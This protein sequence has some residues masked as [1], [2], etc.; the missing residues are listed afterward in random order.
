MQTFLEFVSNPRAHDST[1]PSDLQAWATHCLS[2]LDESELRLLNSYRNEGYDDINAF[3]RSNNINWH[4][5]QHRTHAKSP[6]TYQRMMR[7]ATSVIDRIFQKCRAPRPLTLF[8]GTNRTWIERGSNFVP[9]ASNVGKEMTFTGYSSASL[10]V[11]VAVE[12]ST[13]RTF[14]T[15][16]E[17][18]VPRG[19]PAIPIFGLANSPLGGKI[20]VSEFA[21]IEV[22]L[23]NRLQGRIV[24]VVEANPQ[25]AKQQDSYWRFTEITLQVH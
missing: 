11:S 8:R 10:S 20:D 9:G 3:V 2:T 6:E 15:I 14:P 25:R 21:E 22:L 4:Q 13:Q 17:L 5:M 7:G 1:V 16:L 18:L 24:K 23:P 19:Y 12:F